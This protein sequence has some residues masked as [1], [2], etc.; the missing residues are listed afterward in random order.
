MHSQSFKPMNS[1]SCF[2]SLW[3]D[4][5]YFDERELNWGCIAQISCLQAINMSQE[6]KG[7]VFMH[8]PQIVGWLLL[9]RI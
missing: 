5:Q 9:D 8:K 7:P 4:E 2:M 1:H 6:Y 3:R